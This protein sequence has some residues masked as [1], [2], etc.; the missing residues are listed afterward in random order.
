MISDEFRCIFLHP[1]KCGGKSVEQAI[2]NVRPEPG[3]ADHRT[4]IDLREELSEK[5][6]GYFKFMFCRNPWE[7]LVSIY[8]GRQ[9]I[10]GLNLPPFEQFVHEADP[11]TKPTKSQINWITDLNGSLCIDFVGRFENYRAEWKKVCER[12]GIDRPL[13]W[14]NRSRHE[15]YSTYYTDKLKNI[16]QSKYP[17]DI[18]QFGYTFSRDG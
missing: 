2:W 13:P 15:H 4:I 9:Q 10:L 11:E 1:I 5:V 14:L 6:N 12:I 8:F 18:E 17:A 7:R 3:S 16:V